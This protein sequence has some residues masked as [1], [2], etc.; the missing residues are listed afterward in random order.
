[1]IKKNSSGDEIANMNCF[2]DDIVHIEANAYAHCTD[3]L[4]FAIKF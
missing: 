4:I 3:F 1:M 2:H